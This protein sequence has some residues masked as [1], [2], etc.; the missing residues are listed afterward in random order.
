MTLGAMI[1]AKRESL[2]LTQAELTNKLFVSRQ[3]VSRWENGS[4]CPD[5]IMSKKIAIVL[6]IS[7]DE[8]IPSE[9]LD[10]YV[11]PKE[12]KKELRNMLI[13]IFLMLISIWFLVYAAVGNA[14][15]FGALAIVLPFIACIFFISGCFYEE[16]KNME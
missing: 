2:G 4:R 9:D 5:L 1:K 10:G 13:G 6:G 15:F 3:T 7:L 12:P 11:P 16:P 14:T 8:L